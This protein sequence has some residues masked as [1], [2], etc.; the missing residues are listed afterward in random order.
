MSTFIEAIM[1]KFLLFFVILSIII[2]TT[3]AFRIPK[4]SSIGNP[5]I[6][7]PG[8]E[9]PGIESPGIE[10]HFYDPYADSLIDYNHGFE[11]PSIPDFPEISPLP[12]C[13]SKFEI[14]N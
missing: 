4:P 7:N 10:S 6:E 11:T 9:S 14:S 3:F 2:G 5:G 13:H 12:D 8:I 1:K